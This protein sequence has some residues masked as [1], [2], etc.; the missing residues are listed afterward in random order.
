MIELQNQIYFHIGYHRTGTTFLQKKILPQFRDKA[1]II[2]PGEE[3]RFLKQYL[4]DNPSE[5]KEI[6]QF[7]ENLKS[8][9][10]LLNEANKS[11]IVTAE[12][13]SGDIYS[14]NLEMPSRIYKLFPEA[15]IVITIRSQFSIIPSMYE[16]VYLKARGSLSYKKYLKKI[17]K[18]DKFNYNKLINKYIEQFGEDSVKIELYENLKNDQLNFISRILNFMQLPTEFKIGE[19]KSYRTTRYGS[20]AIKG[21]RMTNAINN[22]VHST[23][24]KKSKLNDSSKLYLFGI[25]LS[26]KID[27]LFQKINFIKCKSYENTP[28]YQELI[29]NH[30]K[31]SNNKLLKEFN[32][33]IDNYNYPL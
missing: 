15:K 2:L 17:I 3:N 29:A 21:I 7:N 1:I 11:I 12:G 6:L 22:F 28:Y 31:K 30:Y 25:Y 33:K 8:I 5:K 20:F 24:F 26:Q 27:N 19:N 13:L 14:D 32:I 18:N 9:K 4:I 16:Y 10:P 23:F